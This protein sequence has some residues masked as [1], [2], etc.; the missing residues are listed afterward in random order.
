MRSTAITELPFT[1]VDETLEWVE[2][3][4]DPWVNAAEEARIGASVTASA[5]GLGFAPNHAQARH[6]AKILS[7]RQNAPKRARIRFKPSAI[8][9]L[10]ELTV[11]LEIVSLGLTGVWRVEPYDLNLSDLGVTLQLAQTDVTAGS[12]S[13]A[14]EGSPQALPPEQED[15]DRPARR[16]RRTCRPTGSEAP[17]TRG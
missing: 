3:T 2:T 14:E 16:G 9:A 10:Y 4:G 8:E 13:V 12:W 5:V 15:E 17:A 6:A 11:R 1:Y 7:I